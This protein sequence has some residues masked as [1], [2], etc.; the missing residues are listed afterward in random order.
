[1]IYESLTHFKDEPDTILR[2]WKRRGGPNTFIE[3][4]GLLSTPQLI[5][6]KIGVSQLRI[7]SL[8]PEIMILNLGA[9]GGT[10]L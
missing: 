6:S 7:E 3:Y 2:V 8:S 10:I 5:A 9:T 4:A 1:L